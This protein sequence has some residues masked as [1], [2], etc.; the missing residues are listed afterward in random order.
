MVRTMQTRTTVAR[1]KP[2]R[3][4]APKRKSTRVAKSKIRPKIRALRPSSVDQ[5]GVKP[6]P[7]HGGTGETPA[8]GDRGGLYCHQ[9]DSAGIAEKGMICFPV[10]VDGGSSSLAS[11]PPLLPTIRSNQV[12]KCREI[13]RQ[14]SFLKTERRKGG[15]E[16]KRIRAGDMVVEELKTTWTSRDIMVFILRG[17]KVFDSSPS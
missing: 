2:P 7:G 1:I 5:A 9:D 13:F 14:L 12:S 10:G 3:V 11:P 17:A 6:T 8:C 15:F 4:K 16:N